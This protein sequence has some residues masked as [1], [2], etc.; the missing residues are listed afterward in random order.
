MTLL[1]KPRR[2]AL[3]RSISYEESEAQRIIRHVRTMAMGPNGDNGRFRPTT[4]GEQLFIGTASKIT[5]T[6]TGWITYKLPRSARMVQFTVMGSA[7]GGGGGGINAGVS[8]GGGGSGGSGTCT[9]LITPARFIPSELFLF[10]DA[11]GPGGTSG[12]PGEDGSSSYVADQPNT[13]SNQDMIVASGAN[14]SRGGGAGTTSAGG[15]GGAGEGTSGTTCFSSLGILTTNTGMGGSSGGFGAAGSGPTWGSASCIGS[16]G[17]SG[18]G[19]TTTSGFAGGGITGT[20]P[21]GLILTFPGGIAGAVSANGGTG[22][23]GSYILR[24]FATWGG[25]GGG[26]S[27]TSGF[28]GGNGGN[29]AVTSG[30][31]GGG[32]GSASGTGGTGGNGGPGLVLIEWW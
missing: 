31:G 5:S 23:S 2:S 28:S 24:P 14:P 20:S 22:Q 15:S 19:N 29:G 1:H 18:G 21:N 16:S 3:R 7:G 17:G 6:S 11:G 8:A 26:S 4:I 27:F 9:V 32:A 25:S 30:G 13:T 10:I 12:N